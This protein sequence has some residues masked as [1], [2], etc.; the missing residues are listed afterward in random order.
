[1]SAPKFTAQQRTSLAGRI[2]VLALEALHHSVRAAAEQ[3]ARIK[4]GESEEEDGE[5]T[6]RVDATTIFSAALSQILEAELK[7]PTGSVDRALQLQDIIHGLQVL[8]GE[9]MLHRRGLGLIL[10]QSI[11]REIEQTDETKQVAEAL[12]VELSGI[13]RP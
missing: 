5:M 10:Q 4:A 8:T 12:G 11:H 2:K 13:L 6:P 9:A 1:M 7:A 3:N